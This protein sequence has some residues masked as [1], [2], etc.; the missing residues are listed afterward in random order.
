MAADQTKAGVTFDT[1]TARSVERG[2]MTPEIAHQRARTLAALDLQPGDRVLDV[3]CGPGLLVHDMAKTVG[4]SGQVTGIDTSAAMLE[5]ASGRCGDLPQ[6]E[7]RD[8][9]LRALPTDANHFDAIACT[10]VLLFIEDLG[11]A[12]NELA[13]VL[14]PGGR[15]AVLETDWRG[16]ILNTSDN[17]L[18]RRMFDTWD[19]VA[20]SPNLPVR[21]HPLLG[22]A[23]FTDI[24]VEGIP[25]INTTYEKGNFSSGFVRGLAHKCKE[26][27][28]ISDAQAEAW[29]ADFEQKDQGG[30][31]FFCVNRFLFSAVKMA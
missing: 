30:A 15:I 28:V 25:I 3:G 29:L 2:Y 4:P 9:D 1:K 13:R 20:T 5:L 11:A 19:D 26:R 6:V 8:D 16:C 17:A 21:L 23:G 31:Y 7:L 12:L 27:G 24:E 14:K 18:T 10:Q 22:D